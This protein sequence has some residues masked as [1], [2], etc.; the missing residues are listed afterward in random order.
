VKYQRHG[1]YSTPQFTVAVLGR[2]ARH[3]SAVSNDT[4]SPPMERIRQ[5]V[6]GEGALAPIR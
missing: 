2:V 4:A 6:I 1:N 3:F 5:I